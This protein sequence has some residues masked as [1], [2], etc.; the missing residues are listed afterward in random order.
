MSGPT[1]SVAR[2]SGALEQLVVQPFLHHLQV[3]A[4][5]EQPGGVG[6]VEIVHFDLEVQ[7]G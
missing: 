4:A 6:V 2:S 5:G 7:D 1:S 3:G